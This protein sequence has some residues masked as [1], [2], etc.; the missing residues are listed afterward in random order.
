MINK[1]L[2]TTETVKE[3]DSKAPISLEKQHDLM[4]SQILFH[5]HITLLFRQLPGYAAMMLETVLPV[6]G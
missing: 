3:K 5:H 2:N 1:E 6:A 4:V